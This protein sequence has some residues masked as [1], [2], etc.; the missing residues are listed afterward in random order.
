VKLN[1]KNVIEHL[2]THL[3]PKIRVDGGEV[4]FEKLNGTTIHL[5]AHAECATCPA[6]AECLK[7]WCEQEFSRAFGGK[8]KVIIHKRVP[9][10]E[11]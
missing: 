8:V 4:E 11:R 2:T 7:W 1:E 6:T 3:Q 5:G 9:Y 10:F